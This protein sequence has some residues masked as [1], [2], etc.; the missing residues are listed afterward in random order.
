MRGVLLVFVA[1][2]GVGHAAPALKDRVKRDPNLVGDWEAV[3]LIVGGSSLDLKG[4]RTGF[5]FTADGQYGQ[6]N[7][8]RDPERLDRF[9]VNPAARPAT[10]DLG[11]ASVPGDPESV[12]IYAIDG[13]R[14]TLCVVPSSRPRPTEFI[15][16]APGTLYVLRRAEPR[17]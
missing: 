12:G 9:S 4:V 17:K 7:G 3:E 14:L 2:V 6:I 16:P 13:D 5:R 8:D 1:V 11:P 15:S 10:I